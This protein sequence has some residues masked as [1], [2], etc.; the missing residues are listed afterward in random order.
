MAVQSFDFFFDLP[1]ELREQILSHIC[2]FPTGINVGGGEGGKTVLM[3]APTR[4]TSTAGAHQNTHQTGTSSQLFHKQEEDAE[5]DDEEGEC[6]SPPVNLFLASPILYRE[7]GDL[8]YGRNDFHLG[9]TSSAWGRKQ[10]SRVLNYSSGLPSTGTAGT[11]IGALT[12]LLTHPDTTYA[13]RRIRS[14]I[15]YVKRFGA[16]V[17]DV[18]APA[19]GDMV[20][21]GALRRVRVDVMEVPCAT[22]GFKAAL[23]GGTRLRVDYAENPAL[24]AV[25][26]LLTDPD[27]ER[28]ELR[29]HRA[30]HARF[31]CRLHPGGVSQQ[32]DIACQAIS[33]HLAGQDRRHEDGFMQVDIHRLVDVCAGD[34]AEFRIK[35]VGV[36]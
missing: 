9:V 31:W 1:P 16:L 26:K 2:L 5:E 3:P 30:A 28:A 32:G 34:A 4:N 27:M 36:S 20:L 24:R 12:R 29:V 18:L 23:G 8:Y 25:L 15:L 35:K 21:N 6:A 13:R 10:R 14:A 11:G 17:L 22:A 19:L 33:R 7:A